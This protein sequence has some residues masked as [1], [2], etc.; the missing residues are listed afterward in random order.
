M[1]IQCQSG[2]TK[3]QTNVKR[4]RTF[5]LWVNSGSFLLAWSD[6]A[7]KALFRFCGRIGG[8]VWVWFKYYWK[9]L[10]LGSSYRLKESMEEEQEASTNGTVFRS[11]SRRCVFVVTVR[12]LLRRTKSYVRCLARW[13]FC[14]FW[15]PCAYHLIPISDIY[16]MYERRTMIWEGRTKC[17]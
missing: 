7:W 10:W 2:I 13:C 5:W 9:T 11:S 16:N 4:K 14:C 12:L 6:A 8:I 1:P 3:E 15:L 17:R